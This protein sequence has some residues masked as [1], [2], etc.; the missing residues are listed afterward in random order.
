MKLEDIQGEWEKDARIDPTDLDSE[1]LETPKLHAKWI[2]MLSAER[3]LLQKMRS[4]LKVLRH[5]KQEFYENGPDEVTEARGWKLPPKGRILKSDS[6][7]WV[8]TDA[9]VVAL[10][11]RIGIQEEKVDVIISAVKEIS[12]RGYR[13]RDAIEWRKF[14]AGN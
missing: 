3:M 7:R 10:T 1:S 13:I 4:D 9:D 6:G 8:D 2:R 12:G 14:M 11:L 5:E